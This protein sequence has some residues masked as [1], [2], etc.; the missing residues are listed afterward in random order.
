VARGEGVEERVPGQPEHRVEEDQRRPVP[1]HE[2]L[3]A[4]VAAP[5]LDVAGLDVV[6]L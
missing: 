6:D 4:D 1:G 5:D 2:D 3:G